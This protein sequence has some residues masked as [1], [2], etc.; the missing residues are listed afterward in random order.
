[1][2]VQLH[3]CRFCNKVYD[4]YASGPYCHETTNNE[5]YCPRCMEIINRSLETEVSKEDRYTKK[6]VKIGD[7]EVVRLLGKGFRERMEEL[8]EPKETGRLSFPRMT[9]LIPLP[10]DH[11]E[12]Y[13]IRHCRIYVC[14]NNGEEKRHYHADKLCRM[15]DNEVVDWYYH[16]ERDGYWP[17]Y[18]PMVSFK[19]L[20]E[21]GKTIPFDE[22]S[23]EI[24]ELMDSVEEKYFNE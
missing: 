4:Y 8:R 2:D 15:S 13:T 5:H 22:I 24:G 1:M 7:D 17:C 20:Q 16:Y 19:K 23:K 6:I 18:N 9:I 21:V 11:I 12:A 10:Y 3:R 14:W